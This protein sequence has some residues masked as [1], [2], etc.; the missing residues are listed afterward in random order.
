VPRHRV[1]TE[2]EKLSE[3]SLVW[4]EGQVDK[5]VEGESRSRKEMRS[6]WQ[7]PWGLGRCGK[8]LDKAR[9]P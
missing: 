5:K 7:R 9:W 4:L 8:F 3:T 6:G 2:I 1:N